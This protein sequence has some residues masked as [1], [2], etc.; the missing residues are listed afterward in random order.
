MNTMIFLLSKFRMYLSEFRGYVNSGIGKHCCQIAYVLLL[1]A[2]DK[3]LLHYLVPQ[4]LTKYLLKSKEIKQNW[5]RPGNF[6]ICFWII[7][8]HYYQNFISE[9]GTEHQAV[10]QSNF[11]IFLIFSTF[12]KSKAYNNPRGNLHTKPFVLGIKPN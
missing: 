2:L 1:L 10:S 3:F 11:Q 7:F 8:N 12:I 5:T 9:K 6:D 4:F